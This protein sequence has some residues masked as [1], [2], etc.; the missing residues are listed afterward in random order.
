MG[1]NM[2]AGGV[3]VANIVMSKYFNSS[4]VIQRIKAQK[5]MK[6]SRLSPIG[7]KKTNAIRRIITF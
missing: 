3:I 5:R 1:Y 4:K 6:L 7:K 2:L